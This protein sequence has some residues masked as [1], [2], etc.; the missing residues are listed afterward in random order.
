M[1][2]WII[3]FIFLLA[4]PVAA[5]ATNNT[6]DEAMQSWVKQNF[7]FEVPNPQISQDWKTMPM[8]NN[9]DYEWSLQWKDARF[10]VKDTNQN[11]YTVS[12]DG[13]KL[14]LD[15]SKTFNGFFRS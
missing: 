11:H 10:E 6:S 8:I 2:K 4:F 13:E 3:L 12:Y 15:F 9:C 7:G 14:T 5:Y 1:A